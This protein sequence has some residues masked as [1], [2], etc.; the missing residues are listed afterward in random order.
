MIKN[1]KTFLNIKKSYLEFIDKQEKGNGFFYNK[2]GQLMDIYI[3][4]SELIFEEFKKNNQT[5][6]IG[7]SG[8]QGSGKSPFAQIL[9]LILKKKYGFEI[10][11]FSIDDFYKKLSERKKMSKLVHK[12]FLT[13]GVPGTHDIKML[14]HVISNLKRKKF[15]TTL[16]PTFEKSKDDRRKKKNWLKVTKK[17]QIIIFEGWCVGARDQKYADLVKPINTLE[18]KYDKEMIWRKKVNNELKKNYMPIFKKIDK[19]IYLKVPSFKYILKWRT[20]QEKKLDFFSSGKKIMSPHE[21][22]DFIMYYE[23]ISKKMLSEYHKFSDIV[24][25]IDNKHRFKK[26]T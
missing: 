14:N 11:C 16:I 6:I 9:K 25:S 22:K 18:K 15:K 13:R 8:G 4:I 7:L 3:P 5:I 21:I 12:L 10:V 2:L 17:P 23:R 1:K 24:V 26:I 19:L 20:Q